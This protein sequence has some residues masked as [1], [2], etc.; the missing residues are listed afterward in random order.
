MACSSH[1]VAAWV[2]ICWYVVALFLCCILK[3]LGCLWFRAH[4]QINT[5]EHAVGNFLRPDFR[6]SESS[7]HLAHGLDCW[8]DLNAGCSLSSWLR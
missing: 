6:F 4:Q 7:K 1:S 8:C 2:P 5:V 3:Q